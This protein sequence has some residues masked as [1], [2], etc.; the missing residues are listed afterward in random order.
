VNEH[1]QY[2][3]ANGL[4]IHD[5]LDEAAARRPAAVAVRDEK[6][7]WTYGELAEQSRRTSAWLQARGVAARDRVL[8]SVPNCRELVAL[9][10]AVSRLGAVFVPLSADA[11][12]YQL[13]AVLDDAEPVLVIVEAA[14]VVQIQAQVVGL[15]TLRRELADH[16]PVRNLPRPDPS[17]IALLVYTSGSTSAP[18]GVISRHASRLRHGGDRGA[19]GLPRR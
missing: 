1:V 17:A 5:I 15:D 7:A 14:T 6:G 2:A 13:R 18:R 11:R 3:S 10:Y 9:M 12:P 4:L 19:P 16:S 8:A